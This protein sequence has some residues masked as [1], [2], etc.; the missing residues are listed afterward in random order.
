[1]KPFIKHLADKKAAEQ[2]EVQKELFSKL[3]QLFQE[4]SGERN[5]RLM[6]GV[7]ASLV[8]FAFSSASLD[9]LDRLLEIMETPTHPVFKA[10]QSITDPEGR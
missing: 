6:L 5:A 10:V 2:K 3:Q 7:H 8:A 9:I 1:M 4:F